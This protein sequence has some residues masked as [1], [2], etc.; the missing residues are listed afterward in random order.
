LTAIL[1]GIKII[2]IK[3]TVEID[4]MSDK[5]YSISEFNRFLDHASE[6]G[7]LKRNTAQ[8][9]KAATN[10][11]L[12]VLEEAELNDLRGVDLDATFE[13]FQNLKRM[14][15]TGDS[16]RVYLSRARTAIGDFICFVDNPASFKPAAAQRNSKKTKGAES[17]EGRAGKMSKKQNVNEGG[18]QSEEHHDPKHITI[19]VPLRAD[20]TVKISG[21]PADL[22]PGEADRLAAIVKA[23]AVATEK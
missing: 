8:S 16:M 6:K 11:I 18:G 19:P 3:L 15:Y 14:E 23:Y 1:D 10:K 7:I 9:R 4:S 22:T 13:R 17:G 20:L 5:D 2:T 12:D 21:I